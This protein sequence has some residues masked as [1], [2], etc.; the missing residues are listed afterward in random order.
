MKLTSFYVSPIC[1][2]TRASLMTGRYPIRAGIPGNI[3]GNKHGL[4][5]DQ[6]NIATMLKSRGYATACIGKWMLGG[7]EFLPTRRG[8]DRFYGLKDNNRVSTVLFDQEQPGRR[9]AGEELTDRWTEEAIRFIEANKDRPFFLYLAHTAPHFPQIPHPRFRGKSQAGNYG[10][11]IVGIDW[12]VG[13]VIKTLRRLEIEKNTLVIFTS[14]NGRTAQL[15]GEPG[16][17]RKPKEHGPLRKEKGSCF[18]GGVRVPCIA[19]WPGVIPAGSTSGEITSIMD[20]LPTC[21]AL[22]GFV[23]PSGQKL[24]GGNILPILRGEKG[25]KSPYAQYY[26][27]G[28]GRLQAVRSGK[29][30]LHVAGVG[31]DDGALYDLEADLGETQDIRQTHPEVAARLRKLLDDA[32]REVGEAAQDAK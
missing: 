14:D 7:G 30:K 9:L 22:S 29:W 17:P 5:A 25:A 6:L 31:R 3:Y 1:S 27:Y 4:A 23:I 12:S 2:P 10:D 18:E 16:Q 15:T 28:N 21:A 20:L 8:F 19:S 13:E 32:R 24:D 26:Y 11:E